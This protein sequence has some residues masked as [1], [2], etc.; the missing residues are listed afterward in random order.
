LALL[1]GEMTLAVS[2]AGRPQPG[3]NARTL[4]LTSRL[5]CL[6]VILHNSTIVD[7]RANAQ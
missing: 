6:P 5:F 2:L 7:V 1:L 3:P 4:H